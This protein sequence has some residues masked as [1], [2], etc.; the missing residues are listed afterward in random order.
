LLVEKG[1]IHQGGV[2]GDGE[3][4]KSGDEEPGIN[5][6]AKR[7]DWAILRGKKDNLVKDLKELLIPSRNWEEV[8]G[9]EAGGSRLS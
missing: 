1:N 9:I 3:D 5:G 2:F 7:E 4:S 8:W 6:D